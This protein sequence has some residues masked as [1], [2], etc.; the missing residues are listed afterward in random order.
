M[1]L[2]DL[3]QQFGKKNI[4]EIKPGDTLKVHFKITEGGK[5]RIQVFEGICI[6]KKHGA[7]LDGSFTVRKISSGIGV[8]RTF[9][10]HSPLVSKIEKVK[11]RQ[12]RHAKLYHLRDL[13]GKKAK[14]VRESKDYKMWEEALSEEEIAE[15]EEQKKAAAEVKA[16]KKLKEKEELEKKFE[17]AAAAHHQ[18]EEQVEKDDSKKQDAGKEGGEPSVS[19]SQK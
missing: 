3:T 19:A 16:Q 17:A 6:A 15:I 7:S 1:L 8:E 4:P 18:A 11:S 2:Q 13:V 10:I 9:P 5:T 12:V 14:K